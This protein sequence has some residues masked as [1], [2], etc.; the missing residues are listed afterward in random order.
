MNLL[1]SPRERSF[2]RWYFIVHIPIT[3]FIDSS[4]VLGNKFP[5][6]TS[7]VQWHCTHNH[8]FLLVEKPEW[9]WWCVLI[10]LIFQLPL[11]FYFVTHWSNLTHPNKEKVD[12]FLA[13]LHF[14]AL[15]ATVTTGGCLGT[16][17]ARKD[18]TSTDQIKLCLLYL[19]TF[20]IPGRLLLS[21]V[22]KIKE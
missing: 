10:E 18:I 21:K 11:F 4:V 9:L 13:L 20:L 5:V 12:N 1:D 6:W 3:V 16:I 17:L 8:D 19:P 14:Y 2:Y 22:G 7:L 15:L